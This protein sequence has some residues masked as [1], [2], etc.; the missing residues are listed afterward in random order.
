VQGRA[1]NYLP[2]ESLAHRRKT[3]GKRIVVTFEDITAQKKAQEELERSQ[4]DLR[5]LSAHLQSVREEESTRV[6]LQNS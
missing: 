5:N 2:H 1:G 4:Q 3:S 6:A